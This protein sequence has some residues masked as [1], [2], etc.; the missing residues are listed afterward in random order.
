[1]IPAAKHLDPQAASLKDPQALM[2]IRNLELRAP[3]D[4]RGVL[5]RV[6]PQPLSRVFRRVHRVPPLHSGDDPRY[7]DW[8][9]YAR[10]D[11]FCI[12]KFEDETNLRCHLLVDNSHSMAY[13]SLAYT[14]ATYATTLAATLAYFLH[15]QGDAVGLMTFD[16]HVREYLPARNRPGHLRHLMS[17]LERSPEGSSTDLDTPIRR[18]ADIVKKRGLMVLISDLLAPI[19]HLESNLAGLAAWDTN[20]SSSRSWTRPNWILVCRKPGG[21][22]IWNPTATSTSTR[23]KCARPIAANSRPTWA[24]SN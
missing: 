15:L 2:A 20:R 21:I 3:G 14:K 6:A 24:R 5:D 7:L 4:R 19:D 22:G 18:I 12:K 17:A 16:E 1:M 8:R 23:S 9:L 10:S 11:R 13:G